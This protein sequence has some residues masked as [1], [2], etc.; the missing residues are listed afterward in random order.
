MYFS[1]SLTVVTKDHSE[2]KQQQTSKKSKKEEDVLFS[3]EE[4]DMLREVLSP[5]ELIELLGKH[6]HTRT[7]YTL[8][9]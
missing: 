3:K 4:E 1:L 8:Q 9:V 2:T 7:T 6:T 5:N